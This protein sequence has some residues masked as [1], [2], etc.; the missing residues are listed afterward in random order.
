[1]RWTYEF[2]VG[3]F[4]VAAILVIMYMFF[5]LTPDVFQ[6]R[7]ENKY[8][9]VIED[10]SGIVAKTQV[11][12][13]GVV[14]GR[15]L[16]VELEGSQ[17]RIDFAVKGDI[18]LPKGSEIL[19]KEKGL[20]GDVFLEIVRAEDKGE[21][22]KSGDILL[23]SK[24]QVSLSKLISIANAIGKDIK[25]ITTTFADVVGGEE[26]H[27]TVSS[28]VT[29]IRDVASSLKSLLNDNKNDVRELVSN[30]KHTSSSLNE[31]ISGKKE[32][33]KDIVSNIK[34]LTEGLK[35]V[36]KSENR[37]KI[38][39]IIATLDSS[40]GDIK[41]ITEKINKGEGTIG[42]LVTD[43]KV[44]DEIQGAVK[45]LRSMVAPIKKMQ[46]SVDFHAEYKGSERTQGYLS[47]ML[48]PRP[49][50]YYLIGITDTVE[51]EK[52]I[53]WEKLPPNPGEKSP[54]AISA[55]RYHKTY[56]ERSNIR[57][58]IQYAQRWYFAQ[59]RFGLFQTTGGLAGDFFLLNDKVVLSFEGFD[60]R[61]SSNRNFG[62]FKAYSSVLFFNHIY[63]MLGADELTRKN[64]QTG[65]KLAPL[66]FI[67]AGFYFNDEDL[68]S[69][70]GLAAGR[71]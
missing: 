12:T 46:V 23:P 68:K 43:D 25:K 8:Y 53:F 14:V 10:A 60:F 28:I 69:L 3:L 18:K 52:E 35:D 20:L 1:M 32:S 61:K 47:V 24:D 66:Y 48:Q 55:N 22:L 2:K 59:F 44:I 5:V 36:L 30:L 39:R 7:S 50:K 62:H 13:S 9:T 21:Y 19:I 42:R 16:K 6:N 71:F 45:D 49:D 40:L 51:N 38:D 37:E 11:K 56:V 4:A 65:R 70:L 15:V 29:D 58:N 67:G 57:F 63:A 54:D 26:G 64:P 41:K 17:S 34:S 31:V 33:L 27:K